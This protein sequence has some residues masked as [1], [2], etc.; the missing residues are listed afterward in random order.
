MNERVKATPK[1][2]FL[3]L[4]V[5]AMLYVVA[6]V[7]ITL[8]FNCINYFLPDKLFGGNISTYSMRMQIALLVVTFPG[9]LAV[10]RV[11]TKLYA[12]EP[13]QQKARARQWLLYL[14][15]FITG[16]TMVVTIVMVVFGFLTGELTA[17]LALK[18]LTVFLV[19]GAV[20]EYH[21]Q[22]G[23]DRA[24]SSI[25]GAKS[26]AVVST[27]LVV[28]AISAGMYV[29]GSP[30]QERRVRLD[31]QKVDALAGVENAVGRYWKEKKK[32]PE[33]LDS[34]SEDDFGV[35]MQDRES[36]KEYEYK[37]L[38]KEKF[39][40]CAEFKTSNKQGEEVKKYGL[41]KWAHDAGKT[42]FERTVK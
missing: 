42:C 4:A 21:R 5:F 19:S 36:V 31:E 15:L 27:C 24:A 7:F 41:D 6:Y 20:F 39:S 2:F 12:K 8:V 32:L 13:E 28:L 3:N 37:V 38:G 29:A 14:T 18:A 11:L 16:V 35:Y 1:E 34:L 33:S 22:I 9:F 23:S 17:P 40:L 26:L 25:L 30:Y 10:S